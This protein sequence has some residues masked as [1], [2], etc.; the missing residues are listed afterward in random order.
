MA[1]LKFGRFDKSSVAQ[2]AFEN[3]HKIDCSNLK[4]IRNIVNNRQMLLKVITR[5]GTWL[6]AAI[7]YADHFEGIKNVILQLDPTE[8][9]SISKAQA[10]LNN[11]ETKN[12]FIFIKEHYF[13]LSSTIKQLE[14]SDLPLRESFMLIEEIKKR[15]S[16]LNNH[17][18]G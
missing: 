8:S 3:D 1:H 9:Q 16:N 14:K 12:D 7:F 2:H 18:I 11:S 15:F 10:V 4:L 6:N 5:W 17:I 13:I